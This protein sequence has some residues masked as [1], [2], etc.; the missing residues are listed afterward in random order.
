MS[1]SETQAAPTIDDVAT[2]AGVSR[3]TVSRALGGYGQVSAKARE[4]VL[5]AAQRLDYRVNQIARSTRTGRSEALGLVVADVGERFFSAVARGVSDVAHAAG[6]QVIIANTDDDAEV[7]AEAFKVL[8]QGRV[9]GLVVAPAQNG[10]TASLFT[11]Q[12]VHV[13]IVTI[14]RRIADTTVDSIVFDSV[15]AA[16]EAV[17]HLTAAGHRNIAIITGNTAHLHQPEGSEVITPGTER[18]RGYV[19]ALSSA[20]IDVYPPNVLRTSRELDDVAADVAVLLAR[21]NRP[22]ALFATDEQHALGTLMGV[23]QAGLSVPEDVSL[24]A[25]DDPEWAGVVR[26]GLSVVAQPS[27]EVGELAAKRLLARLSGDVT[28][29]KFVMDYRWIPRKSIAG[30]PER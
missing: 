3:S 23:Q 12:S 10:A 16:Y 22:T 18:I 5:D 6:Y 4:K 30:P 17:S 29:E 21:R 1:T 2:E 13:P 15:R 8:Q 14:D 28:A 27:H 11:A 19:D 20:G 9:D 26:P 24:V 25:I 7:E